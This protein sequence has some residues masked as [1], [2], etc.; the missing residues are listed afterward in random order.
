[1]KV[2]NK[3]NQPEIFYEETHEGLTNGMPFMRIEKGQD[4]PGAIF[5]GAAINIENKN[6]EADSEEEMCEII[7]QMYINSETLKNKLS[8]EDFDKVR[9]A[10]GLKP[11]KEV[12]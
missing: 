11:L 2:M 4:I 5:M 8:A 3:F 6:K 10:I 12:L 7:M 1:M 9:E